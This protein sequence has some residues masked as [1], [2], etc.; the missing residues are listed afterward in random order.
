[1]KPVRIVALVVCAAILV[2]FAGIVGQRIY[3]YFA[4]KDK[5]QE[6][7]GKDAGYTETILKVE[8]EGAHITFG[9]IFELCDKSIDGRTSLV[10][11]LRGLYPSLNLKVKGDLINYLIAENEFARS[12]RDFYRKQ[13]QFSAASDS[14]GE[15]VDER[16]DALKSSSYGGEFYRSNTNRRK[17]DLQKAATDVQSSAGS[18]LESYN[19]VLSA[20]DGM[21][22][23]AGRAGIKFVP[24]FKEYEKENRTAATSAQQLA[25]AAFK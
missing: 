16:T 5:L 23:A 15:A 20:E 4:I 6:A 12:K 13:M 25:S 17:R 7:V 11:E 3:R 18:F 24:V 10:I 9:E 8:N 22:L 2:V 21:A 14:F 19:T 1:M